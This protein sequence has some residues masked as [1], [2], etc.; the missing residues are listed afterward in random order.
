MKEGKKNL[1]SPLMLVLREQF[2][3]SSPAQERKVQ[4]GSSFYIT[5]QNFVLF[6]LPLEFALTELFV[7]T[8]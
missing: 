6:F 3:H 7:F 4:L 2:F 5:D 8:D 1:Y